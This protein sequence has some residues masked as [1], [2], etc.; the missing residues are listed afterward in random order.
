MP[1]NPG[2]PTN[3]PNGEPIRYNRPP[4]TRGGGQ[5]SYG[6]GGGFSGFSGASPD[7]RSMSGINPEM[8]GEVQRRKNPNA[9]GFATGG[10]VPGA[11]PGPVAPIDTVNAQLA[12]NEMVMNTGVTS[13]P[14]I[15]AILTLLNILGARHVDRDGPGPEQAQDDSPEPCPHCG[16]DMRGDMEDDGSGAKSPSGFACGGHVPR[17]MGYAFGGFA[18][19]GGSRNFL[20]GA[21]KGGQQPLGGNQPTG[22]GYQ[23]NPEGGVTGGYNAANPWGQM[24][25]NRDPRTYG[26]GV[27]NLGAFGEAGYFDPRG[28]QMLINSQNEA[29]QGTADSLVRRQM[30]Q[31]DLG[32]LDPAQRAVAKQQALRDTGRGVQ[33]IMA[34]TRA[35]A[36]G[37]QDAWAK[38]LYGTLLSGDLGFTG[39]DQRAKLEDYLA[40][41][42]NQRGKKG[43]WGN[44]AGQV[45]GAGIGGYVGGLAGAVPKP[46][47]PKTPGSK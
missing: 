22:N 28:N 34:Q 42:A 47:K 21:Q 20:G 39:A 18:N 46:K 43:Q 23:Y 2:D 3:D 15:S 27:R 32:G 37:S 26:Q 19:F 17:K 16:E 33:D 6:P 9:F 11:E 7:S 8:Y 14:T 13:D 5:G 24:T 40:N 29:A 12:P 1:W 10:F 4:N 41:Q 35:D 44:I 38:N 25:Q 45:A 31:A 36:L 30:T